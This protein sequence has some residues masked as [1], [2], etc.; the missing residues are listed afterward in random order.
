MTADEACLLHQVRRADRL[1]PEAQVRYGLRARLLRVVDEVPLRVQVLLG[2]EDLDR[3]LV[4][5]DRAVRTETEEDRADR[6]RRLDVKRPVIRQAQAGHVVDDADR[7]PAPRPV[8][9]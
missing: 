5:A 1:R 2:A 7:E 8:T 9:G 4:R 6:A 3:V